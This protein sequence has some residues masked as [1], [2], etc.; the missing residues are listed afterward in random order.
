M[1][2]WSY[3]CLENFCHCLGMPTEEFEGKILKLLDRMRERRDRFKRVSGKKRKGQ[4][5]S[6]F[7]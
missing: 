1:E 7:D 3:S 5:S 4:R 6:R 2:S